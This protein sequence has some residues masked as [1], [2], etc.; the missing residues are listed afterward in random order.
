MRGGGGQGAR[1]PGGRVTARS[2]P[3]V[4]APSRS[5]SPSSPSP[6]A[7]ARRSRS[8]STAL[9]LLATGLLLLLLAGPAPPGAAAQP[10]P[11][12]LPGPAAAAG[13]A[14]PLPRCATVLV[15]SEA[16]KVRP[17]GKAVVF[18]DPTVTVQ[19]DGA[20][21]VEMRPREFS[22]R[23]LATRIDYPW[24]T[25]A[26][27]EVTEML[28]STLEITALTLYM[29][30]TQGFVPSRPA[31]AFKKRTPKLVLEVPAGN[32]PDL[33]ALGRSLGACTMQVRTPCD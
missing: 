32:W 7:G 11:G 16:C 20:A 14:R 21:A 8:R 18:R 25:F 33:A 1:G 29:I 17:G 22:K 9:A 13:R 19:R 2:V 4:H 3:A 6:S 31:F 28:L 23:W 24:G 15:A 10:L 5:P 27:P 12:A 26:H 30:C